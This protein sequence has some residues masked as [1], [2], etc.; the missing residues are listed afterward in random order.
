MFYF[1]FNHSLAVSSY[2]NN[3]RL[4]LYLSIN[5]QDDNSLPHEMVDILILLEKSEKHGIGDKVLEV[6]FCENVGI[7]VGFKTLRNIAIK[8]RASAR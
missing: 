2:K 5:L 8:V 6:I 4:L 3:A 1:F 7:V